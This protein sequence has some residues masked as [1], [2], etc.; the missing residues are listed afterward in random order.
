M[1]DINM[2]MLLLQRGSARGRPPTP[3]RQIQ[4]AGGPGLAASFRCRCKPLSQP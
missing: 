1:L 3:A 2:V 4:A